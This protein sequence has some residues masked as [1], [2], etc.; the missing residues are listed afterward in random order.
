MALIRRNDPVVAQAPGLRDEM[1]RLFDSFFTVPAIATDRAWSTGWFPAIDVAETDASFNVSA[2]LPGLK[3]DE[4]EI[5]LAGNVLTLKGEKKEEKDEK[6]KSWHRVERVYGSFT[7]T[8]HLPESIDPE[9]A[10]ASFDNGVLRIEIAKSAASR[11]R[12]IKIDV[13]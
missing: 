12:T 2:E 5:N 13:R 11:P 4:V 7:R 1:N 10:K 6:G 3:P 8:L 9:K